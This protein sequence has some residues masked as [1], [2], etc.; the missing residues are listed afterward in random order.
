MVNG[1]SR[2][3]AR[4]SWHQRLIVLDKISLIAGIVRSVNELMALLS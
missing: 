2:N 1:N 3:R 4:S